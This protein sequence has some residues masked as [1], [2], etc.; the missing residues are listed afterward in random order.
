MPILNLI[1]LINLHGLFREYRD[2]ITLLAA[3]AALYRAI[4][5]TKNVE[6]KKHNA[7]RESIEF[8]IIIF[9]IYDY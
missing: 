9:D 5:I 6:R 3:V 8:I 2:G 4:I 1:I 7:P